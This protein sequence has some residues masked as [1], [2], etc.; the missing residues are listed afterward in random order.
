MTET[1]D[2]IFNHLKERI[3]RKE[4][5]PIV[6]ESRDKL[7]REH[8]EHP[9]G[10]HSEILYKVLTYLR[11]RP[12]EGRRV[13][14]MTEPHEEWTLAKITGRRGD[15]PELLENERYDSLADAEHAVFCKRLDELEDRFLVDDPE[16]NR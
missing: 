11:R 4:I 9:F 12:P 1:E 7:V 3:G 2:E 10:P 16:A 5:L 14:V 6:R 15:P 8:R 13:V